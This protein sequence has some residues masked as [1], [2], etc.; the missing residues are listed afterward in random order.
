V[1]LT[2]NLNSSMERVLCPPGPLHA[3]YD[4]SERVDPSLGTNRTGVIVHS[5]FDE[6]LR[7]MSS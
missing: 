1:H 6:L 2:I 3:I 5:R 4:T 7:L